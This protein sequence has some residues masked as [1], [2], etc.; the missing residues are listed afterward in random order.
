MKDESEGNEA[1]SVRVAKTTDA[2]E[3]ALVVSGALNPG[4]P[5][6]ARGRIG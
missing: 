3:R 1:R 5:I 6:L 4:K 2:P